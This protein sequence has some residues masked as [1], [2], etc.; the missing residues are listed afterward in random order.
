MKSAA[1][2]LLFSS[3]QAGV[4]GLDNHRYLAGGNYNYKDNNGEDWPGLSGIANNE[5]GKP[6][7]QSPIDLPSSGGTVVDFL[8][9]N[10][11]K[12]YLN[13]KYRKIGWVGDTSKTSVAPKKNNEWAAPIIDD[14]GQRSFFYSEFAANEFNAQSEW[15]ANQFHFHTGS[16]HTV[17][18]V[19]HDLEMHTVHIPKTTPIRNSAQ[20]SSGNVIAAAMGIFFS[21]DRFDDGIPEKDVAIIDAFFD[22]LRWDTKDANGALKDY[23]LTANQ[24]VTY[25]DLMMMVNMR[26]R[27]SYKGSVTTPPCATTVYWNVV[28]TIYPIKEKHLNLFKAQMQRGVGDDKAMSASNPTNYRLIQDLGDRTIYHISMP[29]TGSNA[30]GVV[31]LLLILIGICVAA[32]IFHRNKRLQWNTEEEAAAKRGE[33]DRA[34][35]TEKEFTDI[36]D[37]V[38][39]APVAEQPVAEAP[40]EEQA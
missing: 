37:K 40:K 31:I 7:S 28:K 14:I 8:S 4:P 32:F 9:D 19:R 11:N 18:G 35:A 27:W 24:K 15:E 17:D 23:T 39:T 34:P 10:F 12:A 26:T 33:D 36:K 20:V 25:G 16:E 38:N 2:A 6:N 1:L 21:T 30:A 22:S 13:Q 5:C 3:A 29:A